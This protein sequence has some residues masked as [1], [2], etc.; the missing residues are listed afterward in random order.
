MTTEPGRL[1]NDDDFVEVWTAH[2]D[3]MQEL[4]N[5]TWDVLTNTQLATLLELGISRAEWTVKFG[6]R[7]FSFDN[8]RLKPPA[9][10]RDARSRALMYPQDT[11]LKLIE[12]FIRQL[13]GDIRS[14]G[15]DRLAQAAADFAYLDQHVWNADDDDP[16]GANLR[17][18]L[19]RPMFVEDAK[20]ST[21]FDGLIR[22]LTPEGDDI[23]LG[24]FRLRGG[25]ELVA[26]IAIPILLWLPVTL[27]NTWRLVAFGERNL[28]LLIKVTLGWLVTVLVLLTV[29]R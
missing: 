14:E 25:L 4:A 24:P 19:Q 6:Y 15:T 7:L 22:R 9:T 23:V 5:R 20:R 8:V 26:V 11:L 3:A 16:V 28:W 18:A 13:H 17:A 2:F 12:E 21:P 1:S 27:A 29:A 10:L